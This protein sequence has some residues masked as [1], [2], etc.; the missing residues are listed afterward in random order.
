MSPAEKAPLIVGLLGI[1]LAHSG[2]ATVIRLPL[3]SNTVS[4]E[5]QSI[6]N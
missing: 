1:L 4:Q 5:L 6:G 3:N 2:F